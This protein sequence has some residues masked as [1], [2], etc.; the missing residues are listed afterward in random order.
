[1]QKQIRMNTTILIMLFTFLGAVML[2]ACGKEESEEI[3]EKTFGIDYS[4]RL[5]IP[6]AEQVICGQESAW[7]ITTVKNDY[8]YLLPYHNSGE[9]MEKI[10]WQPEGGN[11]SLINVAEQNGTLYA[12]IFN[13]ED[14]TLF[15]RKR[16]AGGQWSD[17]MSLQPGDIGSYT[18]VGSCFFVDSNEN[19]Y[20]VSG[21]T[22]KLFNKEGKEISVHELEGDICF[23][24]ENS[25]GSVE[26]I[27]S[28]AKEITLYEITESR[29]E[30]KWTLKVS[31][32]TVQGI[33]SSEDGPLCLA[34]NQEIMFIDRESGTLLA[35][36]D[37]MKLGVASIRTGYYNAQEGTLRLYGLVGN[38]ELCCTL[39]SQREESMEQRTEL[40]YGVLE[41][42]NVDAAA[43][44][45]TAIARF[46]QESTEYYVTIKHYNGNLERRN[47]E[48]GRAS[49]RER[50]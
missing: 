2:S 23:F 26:C 13:Q 38:S 9:G 6:L 27:T 19:V 21:D 3:P 33:R 20:L 45:G 25:A 7:A 44:I 22:M 34:T 42:G 28:D 40:V 8:I 36:T 1:M 48:I 11:Y 47:A 15:I 49:C 37:V 35:R 29:A 14:D 16:S 30:E 18:I 24:Q 31:A 46:N 17:I 39:L 5:E 43:S 41:P 12:Q 32:G 50:V 10:E 4:E